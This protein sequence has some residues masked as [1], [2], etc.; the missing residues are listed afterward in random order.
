[1]SLESDRVGVFHSLGAMQVHPVQELV[2]SPPLSSLP[3]Q[4]RVAKERGEEGKP[5][6]FMC[7]D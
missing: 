4:E 7:F 3:S 1:M 2:Q 5:L 6:T